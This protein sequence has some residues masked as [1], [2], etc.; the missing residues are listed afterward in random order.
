MRAVGAR[1]QLEYE[2]S[3]TST[4]P[5]WL[6]WAAHPQFAAGGRRTRIVLPA[7]VRQLLDVWP[8]TEPRHVPW[9]GPDVESTNGLSSG[10]GR[11]LYALPDARIR[12][13]GLVDEDGTWLRLDWDPD[14]VPYCGLWL[15]NGAY[16]R[17][18][19]IALEPATGYYDDL[20]LAVRNQRAP[21][22]HPGKPQRWSL[23]VSLGRGELHD[24]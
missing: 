22:I 4:T 24:R 10:T 15:D 21:Q 8:R 11:K 18:P 3:A 16:A 7:G 14:L 20:A 23:F 6:L 12:S 19:V 2:L 1:L 17:H 13:A 5:L 9:P